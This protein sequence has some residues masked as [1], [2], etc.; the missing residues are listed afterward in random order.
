M[1]KEFPSTHIKDEGPFPPNSS[2]FRFD[3]LGMKYRCTCCGF[4]YP[5]SYFLNTVEGDYCTQCVRSHEYKIIPQP[6]FIDLNEIKTL[7]LE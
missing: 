2:K 4:N 1:K 7:H 3:K 6:T 5:E